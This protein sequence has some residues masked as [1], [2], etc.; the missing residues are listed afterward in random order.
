[1]SSEAIPNGTITISNVPMG[2]STRPERPGRKHNGANRSGEKKPATRHFVGI[3]GEG[4]THRD[5][6]SSVHVYGMLSIGDETIIDDSGLQWWDIFQFIHDY[7]C[8]NPNAV[9]VGFFLK[10]D[11]T[12]WIKTLS[13]HHASEL[14]SKEGMAARRRVNSGGNPKP[15]S[16][17]VH[18]PS[19]TDVWG[20]LWEFDMLPGRRLQLRPVG[21]K[22]WAY[23]MDAGP[24]W[25]CSFLKAIDPSRWPTPVCSEEDYAV[26]L[27]GKSKRSSS[28]AFDRDMVR[29]NVTEN[30]VLAS[31]MDELRS[32]FVSIGI[33]LKRTQW[34]GPGQSAQAWVDGTGYEQPVVPDH[35]L[36]SA[37]SSYY[38]GRFEI[39][40]H[41]HVPGPAYEYDINSA[42]PYAIT[43]LPCLEHGI[44]ERRTEDFHEVSVSPFMLAYGSYEGSDPNMG[45]LPHRTKDGFIVFP[46]KGR[47]WYWDHEIRASL[48]AG[49]MDIFRVEEMLIYHPCDCPPPFAEPLTKLYQKRLEVGKNT[50]QGVAMKLVYNS[51]YG[52]FAQSV[53]NP[54]YGNPFYASFITSWCR[55][56][57]DEA[58]GSHPG[59]S[60]ELLM[61]ATDGVY[62]RTP[63][64]GLQ[65]SGS[66]L[67]LWDKSE[68]LNL[69]L[70]MPGVYWDDKSRAAIAGGKAPQFKSRGVS[71]AYLAPHVARIDEAFRA[72]AEG[73]TDDWPEATYPIPFSMTSATQALA[74]GKWHT[75]GE[76]VEDGMRRVDAQPFN[77]RRDPYR[78]GGVVRSLPYVQGDLLETTRYDQ[79]NLI[80]FEG[81]ELSPKEAREIGEDLAPDGRV[82]GEFLEWIRS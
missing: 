45:P 1:M 76:V 17:K 3:D 37:W 66:E 53:G 46:Q 56:M 13:E 14:I 74:R 57:I 33:D 12:N 82:D 4:I 54:K 9:M 28:V 41:G 7:Q 42:Y 10:Y 31:I 23:V 51:L 59:G 65:L 81:R 61:I 44:W 80:V 58:V 19:K 48:D 77:K 29:Y 63:H 64:P 2:K 8:D 47:G 6:G 36:H 30:R 34:F 73:K 21:H 24:F 71:A 70:V 52:K 26:I 43:M 25:Q 32:A 69:T 15:L 78:V 18:S 20:T 50:P 16:V 5:T 22:V 40:Y 55:T 35:V 39:F 75:A 67:G 68:K 62:F 27:E 49:L 60:E 79:A 11:F 72:L 38:G